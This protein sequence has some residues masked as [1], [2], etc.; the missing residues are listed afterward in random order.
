MAVTLFTVACGYVGARAVPELL[1]NNEWREN[2]ETLEVP[3]TALK[4][5]SLLRFMQIL[6][7]RATYLMR[8]CAQCSNTTPSLV[9]EEG[10]CCCIQ[11]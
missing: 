7:A 8:C 11:R 5:H 6:D 3:P 2:L 1:L 9:L 10:W 4:L